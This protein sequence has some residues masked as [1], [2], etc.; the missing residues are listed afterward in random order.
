MAHKMQYRYVGNSGLQVSVLSLGAWITYGNT[1]DEDL[2][3]KCMKAAYDGG[4]NFFDNAEVYML[5]QAETTMGKALTRLFEKDKVEREELVISTKIYW[6]PA[7]GVNRKGL[8]RKHIIEGT[9]AS[10]KRLRLDY[11]DILF[12]HR[13]D[14]TTPLE[15]T[16]RAMNFV[17]NQGWAFYWGTSEW[18]S[19]QIAEAHHISR[20]LHLIGP[21]VEQPQY[22]LLHRQRVE[23]E[24]SRL[25]RAPIGLGL[26][27]WSPLA[28][29]LLSGKYESIKREE[30]PDGSRLKDDPKSTWLAN[31]LIN[32]EGINCLD[33]KNFE[34]I[35]KKVNDLKPI[36]KE[37]GCSLAQLS[38]AWCVKNKNVTTVITGASRVEQVVENFKALEF[39]NKLT[40]EVMERIEK[41][42]AN[43]PEILNKVDWR[44][45]N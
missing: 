28:C 29:G 4:C 26:T 34:T 37:L 2:A 31:Q 38:I 8:S 39:V 25:Y 3:Y 21:V 30:F 41:V 19:D 17:I 27:I 13:P 7:K 1:V 11:V 43:K 32:G 35:L 9:K 12:C 23:T 24:Y 42:I 40:D 15:E 22:N 5:G 18:S 33:E 36:A 44:S 45:K 14:D 16:I 6:G 10:L 20:N